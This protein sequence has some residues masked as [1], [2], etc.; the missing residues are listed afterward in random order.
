MNLPAVRLSQRSSLDAGVG[1]ALGLELAVELLA[2]LARR[3][4][5]HVAHLAH[6]QNIV[7]RHALLAAAAGRD[8]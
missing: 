5:A 6:R 8:L 1:A 7:V 3:V 2:V 4:A